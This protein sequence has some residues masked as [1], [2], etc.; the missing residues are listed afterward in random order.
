MGGLGSPWQKMDGE[1]RT[2][3]QVSGP[4]WVLGSSAALHP[5]TKDFHFTSKGHIFR[6]TADAPDKQAVATCLLRNTFEFKN[7]PKSASPGSAGQF[8]FCRAF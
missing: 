3:T 1:D 7:R 4:F 6:H 2:P 5:V 8:L